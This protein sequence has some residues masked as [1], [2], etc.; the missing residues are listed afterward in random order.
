MYAY[1]FSILT[2]VVISYDGHFL[3][4]KYVVGFNIYCR[5]M[6]MIGMAMTSLYVDDSLS[7]IYVWKKFINALC[8]LIL[9][10]YILE[11]ILN[12][13]EIVFDDD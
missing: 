13:L 4:W 10:S 5:N 12:M 2:I 3:V 11:V 9:D 7:V 1:N 8:I 6:V